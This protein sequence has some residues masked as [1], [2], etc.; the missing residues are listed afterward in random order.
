MGCCAAVQV[1]GCQPRECVLR[2]GELLFVPRGW[3]HLAL[4]LEVG[5]VGV[6]VSFMGVQWVWW[7]VFVVRG[8][9]D[10]GSAT[11]RLQPAGVWFAP[12]VGP[13][14]QHPPLRNAATVPPLAC[15]CLQPRPSPAHPPRSPS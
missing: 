5:G 8:G 9:E 14:P 12:V 2:E 15:R 11:W 4:N 3:W 13:G 7:V 1:T 10:G 6:S